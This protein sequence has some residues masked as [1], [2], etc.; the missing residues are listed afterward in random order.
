MSEKGGND[1]F[2]VDISNLG[3]ETVEAVDVEMEVDVLDALIGRT[4]GFFELLQ[5][6][7]DPMGAFVPFEQIC[8]LLGTPDAQ[9][10]DFMT[11]VLAGQ[12]EY[13]DGPTWNTNPFRHDEGPYD[14]N[15]DKDHIFLLGDRFVHARRAIKNASIIKGVV[16]GLHR[17]SDL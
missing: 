4:D 10:S 12:L 1:G 11:P 8:K 2:V 16:R 17:H 13:N 15:G 6:R 5:S 9:Q 3:L 7:P 14:V